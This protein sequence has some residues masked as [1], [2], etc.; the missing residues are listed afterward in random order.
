MQSRQGGPPLARSSR[1]RESDGVAR[2]IEE[3]AVAS[4]HSLSAVNPGST[5]HLREPGPAFTSS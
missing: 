4:Q 3:A 1:V 2:R 5:R